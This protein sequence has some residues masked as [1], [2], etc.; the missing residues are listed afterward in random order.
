MFELVNKDLSCSI[1]GKIL[2]MLRYPKWRPLF[3]I[4][5]YG[6]SFS[7]NLCLGTLILED[8][9]EW[10]VSLFITWWNGRFS[11]NVE[12]SLLGIN[13]LHLLQ[14]PLS[15]IFIL[16]HFLCIFTLHLIQQRYILFTLLSDMIFHDWL[17]KIW[18]LKVVSWKIM[19]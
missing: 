14:S 12:K 16:F 1:F 8:D 17:L 19:W 15:N 13:T 3:L 9:T 7:G 18:L 2:F 4:T 11:D 10:S 5:L 6:G